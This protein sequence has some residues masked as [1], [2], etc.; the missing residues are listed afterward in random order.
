MRPRAAPCPSGCYGLVLAFRSTA[1]ASHSL[2]YCKSLALVGLLLLPF[3]ALLMVA[4][5]SA[6][7]PPALAAAPPAL[8]AAPPALAAAPPALAAAPP[9]L[10]AAPPSIATSNM[11]SEPSRS[12]VS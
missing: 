1:T 11:T 12:G 10:A 3:T 9:A 5:P 6:A 7:A 8:A 4:S 2:V